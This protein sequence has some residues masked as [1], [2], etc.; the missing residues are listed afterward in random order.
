MI[1]GLGMILSICQCILMFLTS[2]SLPSYDIAA[3]WKQYRLTVG[4]PDMEAKF[5]AAVDKAKTKNANARKYPVLYVSLR[6]V[7]WTPRSLTQS[8]II[9]S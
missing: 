4:A 1:D 8:L 6:I 7:A 9:V 3:N 2:S 5:K